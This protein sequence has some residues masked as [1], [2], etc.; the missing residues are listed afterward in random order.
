MEKEFDISELKILVALPL[1]DGRLHME[2]VGGIIEAIKEGYKHNCTIDIIYL[3]GTSLV[4]VARNSL[5]NRMITDKTFDKLVWIDSDIGFKGKD[6]IRLIALSTEY[7]IIAGAYP[8]K[9]KDITFKATPVLADGKAVINEHGLVKMLGMPLGFSV[10]GRE[11][12]ETLLPHEQRFWINREW[13]PEFFKVYV[14]EDKLWGEDI[15]FC[16]Q[17]QKVGGEVWCDPAILLEH[18][19]DASY[20]GNF[21]DALKMQGYVDN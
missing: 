5:A 16:R 19:G 6:L 2:C 4:Q 14:E 13:I 10:I 20:S 9:S 12:F 1:H 21:Y 15:D 8:I 3:K 11:V 7:P 18:F 17:W